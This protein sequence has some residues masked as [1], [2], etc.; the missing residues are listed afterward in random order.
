MSLE[1]ILSLAHLPSDIVHLI[2]S[3]E[4]ESIDEMRMVNIYAIL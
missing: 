1:V 2:I 3:M 4:L